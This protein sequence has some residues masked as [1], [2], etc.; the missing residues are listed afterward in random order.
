LIG[1][2]ELEPGEKRA[3]LW[4]PVSQR[5]RM[6]K[7][8][9]N[10]KLV[11]PT[12]EE[13]DLEDQERETLKKAL[14][15]GD[16]SWA[17][18]KNALGIKKQHVEFNLQKGGEKKLIGDRT[19]GKLKS[20]LVNEWPGLSPADLEEAAGVLAGEVK[21]IETDEQA[22]AWAQQRW[23]LNAERADQF[24][25]ISLETNKYQAESLKA[26][27]I[28][29]PDLEAGVRYST[30]RKARYPETFVSTQ[31]LDFLPPVLR[32]PRTKEDVELRPGKDF[33]G[34]EIRNPAV[35]RTL[36]E[37]RKVVNALIRRYG[38]PAETH[39]ELARDLKAPRKER[40]ARSRRM[41]QR[42]MEREEAAG[43]LHAETG[44]PNPA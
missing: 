5:F 24:A 1:D 15:S 7:N 11:Y 29:L 36:S 43:I 23:G 4:H 3:P 10:L 2:C 39:L 33:F 22:A 14:E 30:S 25:G 17:A 35:V 19:R 20:V 27:R 16:L 21:S 42:E 32:S 13:R 18:V 6:L 12:L 9:N 31:P 44:T 8:L 26:M 28:M 37:M 40:E 41:R 38:K 34:K